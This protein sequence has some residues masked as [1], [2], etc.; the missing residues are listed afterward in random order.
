MISG[1]N[2]EDT[3]DVISCDSSDQS[4]TS[5]PSVLDRLQRK[6]GFETDLKATDDLVDKAASHKAYPA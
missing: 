5:S 6:S 2:S 4:V 3:I 1:D